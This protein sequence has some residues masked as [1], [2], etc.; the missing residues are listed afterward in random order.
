MFATSLLRLINGVEP[1]TPEL[2]KDVTRG[3]GV[4]WWLSGTGGPYLAAVSFHP[5]GRSAGCHNPISSDT[6]GWRSAVT[7]L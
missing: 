6:E 5:S 1:R 3:P 4:R 2:R 7:S